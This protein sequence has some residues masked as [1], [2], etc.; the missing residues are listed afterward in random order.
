MSR[1]ELSKDHLPTLILAVL[2]DGPRHGYAVAR[3]IER[4]SADALTSGE[5]KL[6]PA[7]RTLEA[8]GLVQSKWETPPSGPARKVYTLT[9]SG[10]GTLARRTDEWRAWTQAMEAVL[11]G[12]SHAQPA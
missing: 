3:E 6:Y 7:L 2:T 11:N 10:R 8:D 5:G 12:G 9:D 4:R 1:K